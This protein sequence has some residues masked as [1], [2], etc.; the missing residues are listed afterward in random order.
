MVQKSGVHS[1]VEGKVVY[2]NIL[3]GLYTSKRWFSRRISEASTVIHQF[4]STAMLGRI[5]LVPVRSVGGRFGSP[6]WIQFNGQIVDLS[7]QHWPS[8][9]VANCSETTAAYGTSWWNAAISAVW[10]TFFNLT[11]DDHV[12][13]PLSSSTSEYRAAFKMLPILCTV[14]TCFHP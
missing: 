1:P 11:D 13:F 5:P 10:S 8:T 9:L 7:M 12:F 2:P 14:S 6:K 3:Q 4:Q